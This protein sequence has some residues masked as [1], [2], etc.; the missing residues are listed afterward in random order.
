MSEGRCDARRSGTSGSRLTD[1]RFEGNVS[2]MKPPRGSPTFATKTPHHAFS[3]AE[4]QRWKVTCATDVPGSERLHGLRTI[5][6]PMPR[7]EQ[8]DYL[9]SERK[10]M[11]LIASRPT[12]RS[13]GPPASSLAVRSSPRSSAAVNASVE[14]VQKVQPRVRGRP[15]RALF[16]E[17]C[18]SGEQE[19]GALQ[20]GRSQSPFPSDRS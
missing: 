2:P 10:H 19:R 11:G 15:A 6:P 13:S 7:K 14:A 1:T 17:N 8:A 20:A 18:S 9:Y 16:D 4:I 3:R 5:P 12:T